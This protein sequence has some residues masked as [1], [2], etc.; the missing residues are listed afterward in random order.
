M[1]KTLLVACAAAACL[2]VQARQLKVLAIGNSFSLSMMEELPKAAA[3]F[4]DCELDIANMFIGGCPLAKPWANVEQA[5]EPSFKPYSIKKSY[6]FDREAGAKIPAKA[7]IPEM[8]VADKWDIVTIQQASGQSAFFEKYEPYAGKLIA[9]IRELAPQ[10]EIRVHQTW[11]YSPY[12]GRLKSWKMTP[13]TMY[14]ALKSAYGKLAAAYGFKTIPVGDA[15]ALYRRRLPV[16]YDKV[17][18]KREIAAIPRPGLVDFHGDV[19]G[20]SRWGKGRR[21]AKDADEVKLRLDPSHLNAQGKYL[22]ACVWLAALFDVDVT[23]LAYEPAFKD[24]A[25]QAKLM[26]ECAAAAVAGCR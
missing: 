21:N 20:S 12:D 10:A 24:F 2:T 22:Q 11:S 18:T 6:V 8:L 14:E 13:E 19:A 23:K 4:P 9:N 16:K 7:N 5:T 3:A 1:K 25:P 15:V 26:R 17:L